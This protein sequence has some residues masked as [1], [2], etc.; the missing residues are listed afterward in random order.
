MIKSYKHIPKDQRK[1]ILLLCDDIRV[2]SGVATVGKE[3]VLGTAHYFNW[4]NL[5]GAIKHPEKGKRLDLS[6]SIN[7]EI[8]IDDSNVHVIPVDGYGNST[9][10]RD[11]LRNEKPD[12]L[13]LFTD[14]RYFDWVFRMEN[15]I[16]TKIPMIYLNIWDDLP[17]PLYNEVYYDSCDTLLAI[18][19]LSFKAST[20]F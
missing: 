10:L 6:D 4:V 2:H 9:I 18:S 5:A 16:R 8:G 20:I 7:T 19:I 15:E 17:A 14:P 11:I 13:M 3:I 1:K 12:A